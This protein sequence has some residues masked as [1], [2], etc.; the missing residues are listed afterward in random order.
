MKFDFTT[1]EEK[2]QRV[3]NEYLEAGTHIVDVSEWMRRNTDAGD[4]YFVI[5]F[6]CVKTGQKHRERWFLTERALWRFRKHMKAAGIKALDLDDIKSV[7]RTLKASQYEIT[8]KAK[9][10]RN[11][12]VYHEIDTIRPVSKVA[13]PVQ[14]TDE[15]IPF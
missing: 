5:T 10:P 3:T 13:A 9:P 4:E 14:G 15:E 6:A 2:P 12:V 8:L 11:G 7:D 1:E